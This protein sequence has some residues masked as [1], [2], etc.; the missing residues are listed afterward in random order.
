MVR[1]EHLLRGRH[2]S[3]SRDYSHALGTARLP[4][5]ASELANVCH[6]VPVLFDK[7]TAGWRVEGV[8]SDQNLRRVLLGPRGDWKG[9]YAPF[10]LRIH[11]FRL[12]ITQSGWEV[13]E[14]VLDA[15]SPSGH[16]FFLAD[17]SRSAAYD[18]TL[19][20]LANADRG[21]EILSRLARALE[22]AGL[23]VPLALAFELETVTPPL[24]GLFCIDAPRL[25]ALP[26]RELAQL[27]EGAPSAIDLACASIY[28]LRLLRGSYVGHSAEALDARIADLIR[29]AAE[30]QPDSVSSPRR[31]SPGEPREDGVQL[32]G[33]GLDQSFSIDFG[34][35]F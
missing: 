3:F 23:L 7:G 11:P 8:I 31:R 21:R 26:G 30:E 5:I 29:G 14:S 20:T 32:A 13:H 6:E 1:D 25:S 24:S 28:S 27:A 34:G 10:H 18:R 2:F 16:A 22:Q 33:F 12:A 9:G 19:A 15:S 35:V 4:L 17:G